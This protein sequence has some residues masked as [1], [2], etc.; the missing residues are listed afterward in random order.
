MPEDGLTWVEG[1]VFED[2]VDGYF[3]LQSSMVQM[4]VRNAFSSALINLSHAPIMEIADLSPGAPVPL[5][6]EPS[7]VG[8]IDRLSLCVTPTCL[9]GFGQWRW[10]DPRAK[11]DLCL[12]PLTRLAEP[13]LISGIGFVEGNTLTDHLGAL[14]RTTVQHVAMSNGFPPALEARDLVWGPFPL[15]DGH[16]ISRLSSGAH[17]TS[18]LAGGK[19]HGCYVIHR[20][21]RAYDPDANRLRSSSE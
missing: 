14:C 8:I 9:C 18:T 19:P 7:E 3:P 2:L 16:A 4:L 5:R 13:A 10:M 21:R 12:D 17:G 6:V 11:P 1:H 20:A 15:D